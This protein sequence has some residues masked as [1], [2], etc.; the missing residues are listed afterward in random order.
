MMQTTQNFSFDNF[1]GRETELKLSWDFDQISQ[2]CLESLA[3]FWCSSPI[4]LT[5]DRKI[6]LR[7]F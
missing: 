7:A 2:L 3:T 6:G 4:S 1:G 5:M